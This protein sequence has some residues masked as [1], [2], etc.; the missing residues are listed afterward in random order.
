MSWEKI[1]RQLKRELGREPK[2]W[3]IQN[4]MVTAAFDEKSLLV[5]HTLIIRN[6]EAFHKVYGGK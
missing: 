1:H 6:H 3:E 5:E 4:R 2:S